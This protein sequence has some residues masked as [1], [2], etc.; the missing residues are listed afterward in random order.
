[1]LTLK[2]PLYMACR[3]PRD[4]IHVQNA[5]P[6]IFLSNI[7]PPTYKPWRIEKTHLRAILKT[8]FFD[9]LSRGIDVGQELFLVRYAV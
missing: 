9:G 1:M 2:L 3:Y 6:K 4:A 8:N 7:Y 5:A